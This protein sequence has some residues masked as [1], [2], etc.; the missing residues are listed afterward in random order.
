M[1]QRVRRPQLRRAAVF[2]PSG[3]TLANLMFGVLAIVTAAGGDPARAGVYTVLGGVCDMFDGRIARATGT[4]SRLGEELDSLVDAI[5][6]GLAPALIM[7]FAVLN[8]SPWNWFFVFW[9]ASCAVLRLAR[10]NVQQA[11]TAK[12]HFIGLPSP[13]AGGTLAV[14][15]WFSQTPLYSQTNLANLPWQEMLR[16]LMVALGFLMI[17]NVAYPAVPTVNFRS[18]KGILS[19]VLVIAILAG[20]IL[21]PRE[22]FFPVAMTYVVFGILASFFAGLV[23]RIPTGV[24]AAFEDDEDEDDLY[25]PAPLAVSHEEAAAGRRRRR[26]RRRHRGDRPTPPINPAVE[27]DGT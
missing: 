25:E 21:L 18:A 7:Y 15:Y 26:R 8:A 6:F 22:F 9:F 24:G 3:F 12:T 20:L 10:F 1:R 19:L 23:E 14:Y 17:S 13:A 16:F 5:S 2:L 27:E 4:G 11:G